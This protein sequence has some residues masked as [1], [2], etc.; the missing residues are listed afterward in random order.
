MDA[1]EGVFDH[2]YKVVNEVIGEERGVV[3]D[4]GVVVEGGEVGEVVLGR[5]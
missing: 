5:E 1:D 3:G 4:G 2:L